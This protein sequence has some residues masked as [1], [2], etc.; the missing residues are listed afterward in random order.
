MFLV[1]PI[2]TN[3]LVATG[4]VKYMDNIA[5]IINYFYN[6]NAESLCNA[7]CHAERE[8]CVELEWICKH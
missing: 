5:K 8:S 1:P 4:T 2:T 6:H 7:I 3:W